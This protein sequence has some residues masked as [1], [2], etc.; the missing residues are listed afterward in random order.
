MLNIL[1][2]VLLPFICSN[3]GS[4]HPSCK[5]LVVW[6]G[7]RLAMVRG[8]STSM[9]IQMVYS[10]LSMAIL[11]MQAS[12]ILLRGVESESLVGRFRVGG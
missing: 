5:P 12:A 2:C 1:E 10:R 7:K 8:W 11:R 3:L 6:L 9:G 4:F